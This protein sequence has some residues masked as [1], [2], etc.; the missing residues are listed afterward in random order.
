MSAPKAVWLLAGGPMQ[1]R[2]ARTVKQLGY[3]LI[4]TD[5]NPDCLCRQYADFFLEC[6]TFDIQENLK[7]AEQIRQTYDIR[8][9]VTLAADCHLTVAYLCRY[10][11]IHGI[12]PE[13]AKSCRQK[14]RTREILSR[15]GIAQPK[16]FLASS[17]RDARLGLELIGGR[18]VVKATD[19][20]ASRGFAFVNSVD[21]LTAEV[22]KEALEAGTTNQVLIEEVLV[23]RSDCI[24]EQSVETLWFNGSMYWLNWV[25]RLF[26]DDLQFFPEINKAVSSVSWAVE[27]GHINPAIHHQDIKMRTHAVV[28]NAG[29]ALGMHQE[30]GAHILK[31]DIMQTDKGPIIIELTPRLS[32]GW[33]S[34]GTGPARGS[35]FQLG[36]LKLALGE[37]LSVDLW[38]ECFQPS[39]PNLY[40]SILADIKPGAQ[41]CIGRQFSMG[42]GFDRVES[43]KNAL[44]KL[45]ELSYVV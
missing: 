45:K 34:S 30:V 24:A 16:F 23:P 29:R 38:M 31:A 42:V 35:D 32:G 20:S 28:E 5:L 22:F 19:N 6:D 10:L 7:A 12:S 26:R 14:V 1:E 4:V 41:N 3:A 21:E 37:P 40:A 44:S 43:L 17:L 25:D 8:A 18:G 2:F 13:I 11:G 15:A 27:I 9:C 39:E 33:D 36:Y